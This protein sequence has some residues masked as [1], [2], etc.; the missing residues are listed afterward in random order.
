MVIGVKRDVTATE[1]KRKKNLPDFDPPPDKRPL[2]D[3]T[4]KFKNDNMSI[5]KVDILRISNL[6]LD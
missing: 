4:P 2:A 5:L 6:V 1:N 3:V